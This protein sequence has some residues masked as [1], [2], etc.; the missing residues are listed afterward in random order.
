MQVDIVGRVNNLQLPVTQPCIP[1]FECLVNSIESIEDAGNTNGRIDVHIDRD[2]RQG[3]VP[4]SEETVHAPIRDITVLDNGIGFN[5]ANARAFF[6][7]DSTRKASRGNKG[8]GRFTWLKVFEKAHIESTYPESEAWLTRNFDFVKTTEGVEKDEVNDA[9]SQGLRTSVKLIDLRSEYQKHFPKSLE[10]IGHKVIDHLLIHF[11]SGSCPQIWLH[12]NVGP[13][14]NL[15]QVFSEE[16]KERAVEVEFSIREQTFKATILRYQSSSVKTHTISYCANQRE[17]LE[18][19]ASSAIPDLK[20]RLTDESGQQFVFR[21][22][23]SGKYLDSH[24]NSERTNFLFIQEEDLDFPDEMTRAELDNSVVATLKRIAGPYMTALK[25]EKRQGIESFVAHKAPQFRFILNDRYQDHLEKISPNLSEDQL[26]IELYKAQRDIEIEHRQ[27]ATKINSPPP[28]SATGVEEYKALYEQYLEQ[29]NELGKAAL[30]KYVIHR[31]TI[32]ELLDNAL[33]IQEDGAYA[34]EDL[35][36]SL[37]YPMRATSEDVEFSKQNLWVVD[38]RLAYHWYLASDRTLSSLKVVNAKGGDE[39]DI[40]VFNTPRAFTESTSPYQS[41]VLVEFKRP[42]R[43]EYPAKEEDPVEQILRYVRKIKDG[44][45]KDKDGKTFTVSTIPFYAYILCSLTPR[46]R[47]IAENRDF[48]RMPDNEGYFLYHQNAG[49]YIEII[50]YDKVLNDAKKRN[51][52]FFERLQ[53]PI[54]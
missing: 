49:C 14:L 45:A 8:I 30:A 22:Y 5:D 16:A 38:E 3:T 33:K 6:M 2:L 26:D 31:R 21:T 1:L 53:L 25:V 36:H 27:Q 13:A 41:V 37:I 9:K 7:S 40:V 44:E 34:R 20:A 29:E 10:T 35:V 24:V 50:S 51:R 15:N 32:L 48:T 42:E 17:V 39:P 28:E 52:A 11:V 43:N 23:I 12:D 54:A 47:S 46:M 4:G 19:K 18:W